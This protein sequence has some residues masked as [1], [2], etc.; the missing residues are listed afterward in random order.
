MHLPSIETVPK[1]TR[2]QQIGFQG[3]NRLPMVEAGELT[4]MT[5]ISPKYAPCLYPRGPREVAWV[6]TNGNALFV[7]NEKLCWV[8]GT[9][10]YYDG[11][12]KGT[13]T[14][15]PKSIDE[16][17][18]IILIFPDK[19]YY[20]YN[21]D[22][23]GT[24]SNCP[25][26]K[27]VCVHNNRAYGVGGNG[28][29]A[30]KAL[31]P[32]TWN[33]LPVPITNDS[34][35]QVNTGEPG[36]FTGI[37][38]W[39]DQVI[40]TKA[41][42][43]Y[44]LLGDKPSNFKLQKIVEEGC[45]DYRSLAVVDGVLYMLS[46]EGYRGY[47]GAYPNIVSDKLNEKYV[48]GVSGTDG[49][50]YYASLYNGAEYNLY[51]LYKGKWYREDDLHVIDFARLGN[52]L[53][54]LAADNIIYKFNS[55]D[56]S[57]SWEIESERFTEWHM[58]MKAN[59]SVRVMVE[60]EAG[61]VVDV[62]C[63]TDDGPYVLWKIITATGFMSYEMNVKPERCHSLKIKLVGGGYAKV[64]GWGREVYAGSTIRGGIS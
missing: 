20:N 24:I 30:S 1:T 46:P 54:A 25:D 39:Q 17:F 61:A 6:L 29:Y 12:S 28:F 43:T 16:Y 34:S 19:K 2:P 3:L 8:D 60:L 55:G 36:D 38:V 64:Y 31:D 52:D 5:N 58:G 9:S 14:A 7:A 26:I 51:V 23:F 11:V 21:T 59:L 15:G 33:Y 63:S 50:V 18:G 42:Y 45:I 44:E 62:H 40:A 22:T 35:W 53:Y 41:G 49:T 47:G 37:C 32:L 48:N 10:F 57:P 13:V 4:A 56:E 27:C